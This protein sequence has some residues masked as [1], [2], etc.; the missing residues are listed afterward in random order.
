MRTAKRLLC[1]FLSDKHQRSWLRVR[2]RL[3]WCNTNR[4]LALHKH[5]RKRLYLRN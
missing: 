2:L 5:L 1:F 3:R 4:C